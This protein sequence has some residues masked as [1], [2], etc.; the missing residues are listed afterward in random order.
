MKEF[1]ISKNDAGQRMDKFI[2]KAIPKL[3]SSLLYKY[4]RLKR[5]KLNGKRCEISTRLSVGDIVQ[6][7]VSDEFFEAEEKRPEFMLAPSAIDVVFEDENILLVNKPAGLLVHEG[8][9][10]C[11]DTLIA[12]IQHYLYKKGEYDPK[13][14]NSFVPALC[15]RIDRNTCGIVIAAKNAATLRVLNDKIKDR[16]LEKKYL[17]VIKG[18]PK[19]K[20]GLLEHFIFKNEKTNTV[21]ALPS[22]KPG[23][24]TAK[25]KYIVL[26]SH[27]DMSLCEAELL[28]GRTHQIRAQFAAI[29]HPLIGDTKYGKAKDGHGFTWQALCSYKL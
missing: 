28:T 11:A 4:I 15:N 1:T 19:K 18:V 20:T 8:D 6:C 16:E 3:P 24:K 29:G 13:N 9:Q 7:Y 12:R 27:D 26:A 21:E 23:A 10:W 5:I 25:T 22:P 17:C 2:T 14:E